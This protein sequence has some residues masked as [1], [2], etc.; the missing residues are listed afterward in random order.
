[1]ET[2]EHGGYSQLV[3]EI[4]EVAQPQRC[5]LKPIEVKLPKVVIGDVASW[6]GFRKTLETIIFAS[7]LSEEE[8]TLQ[9]L[10]ALPASEQIHVRGL[11]FER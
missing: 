3:K 10:T 8:K 6:I 2:K 1:M 7:N 5:N 4:R 9:L 11:A